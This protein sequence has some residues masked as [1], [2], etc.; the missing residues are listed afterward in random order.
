MAV[1]WVVQ[2]APSLIAALE[3]RTRKRGNTQRRNWIPELWIQSGNHP[4]RFRSCSKIYNIILIDK[5]RNSKKIIA[6]LSAFRSPNGQIEE[7]TSTWMPTWSSWGL[8]GHG[9]S[10]R[11]EGL[12]SVEWPT[13]PNR[14][15]LAA[16]ACVSPKRPNHKG[17]YR[18]AT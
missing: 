3:S 9:H 16:A 18:L 5:N 15:S 7:P 11:R 8:A 14:G 10:R 4:N 12:T 2:I 13:G 17:S 6:D 1:R